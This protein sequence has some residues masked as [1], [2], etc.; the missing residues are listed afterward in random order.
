MGLSNKIKYIWERFRAIVDKDVLASSCTS[1][2]VLC[3]LFQFLVDLKKYIDFLEADKAKF[4]AQLKRLMQEN[5]WLR[6][7][8]GATQQKLLN[9]EQNVAQL[10]T[11]KQQLEFMNQLK[12]YDTGDSVSSFTF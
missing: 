9:S 1:V 11:E 10:E 2:M 6:D 8:L 4:R 12:K 5:A 7:E 3:T